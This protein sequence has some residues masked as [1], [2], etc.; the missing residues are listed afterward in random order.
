[1]LCTKIVGCGVNFN[2]VIS[3]ATYYLSCWMTTEKFK[4]K[5]KDSLNKS[6]EARDTIDGKALGCTYSMDYV[7]AM[8]KYVSAEITTLSDS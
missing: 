5:L 8:S 4:Q 1:M 6:G 7:R 2:Q 3:D